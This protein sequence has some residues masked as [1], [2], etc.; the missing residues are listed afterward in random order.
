[1]NSIAIIAKEAHKYIFV[2]VLLLILSVLIGEFEWLFFAILLVLLFLFREP[3]RAIGSSD[4][5]AILSPVD[6]KIVGIDKI[7]YLNEDCTQITISKCILSAGS[8]KAPCNAT[9]SEFKRRHGLF[10]CSFMNASNFLNE[11]AFYSCQTPHGK[12][13]MRLISG[14]FSRNLYAEKFDEIK[15]GEKFGFMSDGKVVLILPS[16]TRIS[17]VV[18]EKLKASSLLGFFDYKG[19]R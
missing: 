15:S 4:D 18:G 11:R 17:V 7:S 13:F 3:K 8:L 19:A 14:A 12:L 10:L 5:L 9:L 1:M 16:S 2:G 6:G